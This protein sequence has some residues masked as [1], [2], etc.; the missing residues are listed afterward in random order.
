MTTLAISLNDA[1]VT[2]VTGSRLVY[3]E[4]GFAL[5]GDGDLVTGRRAMAEARRHPRSVV[6]HFWRHLGL[7][8]VQELKFRHL[9]P[10][11]LASRQLEEIWRSER[12]AADGVV[13][14]VPAWM[15]RDSLGVLLGI[16]GELEL[17]VTALVDSAVACSRRAY[18]GRSLLHIDLSLHTATVSRIA[19]EEGA[20][21]DRVELVDAAGL[22]ALRDTWVA[23]IAEAFV[24]QSRFD[25]LHTAESEQLLYDRLEAWLET[26]QRSGEVR[27]QLEFG[28]H[29]HEAALGLLTFTEAVSGIYQ[30][31]AGHVRSLI[32]AAESPALQFTRHTAALPGLVDFL[33]AR[34]GGEPFVLEEAAAARGALARAPAATAGPARLTRRLPWDQSPVEAP[35]A[36]VREAGESPSH[37][38]HGHRA[39]ALDGDGLAIGT[40]L[41][42]ERGITLAADMAG[43]SRRHCVL[44]RD[45]GQCIVEDLSRYG[46][47]LNG[48][49]I[50]RSAVLQA[51]DSL[52]VGTPGQ[53]FRLIRVVESD[54]A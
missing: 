37:L 34:A 20:A 14:A 9:T 11:D 47:W 45:N 8:P 7:E 50:E 36:P 53:E 21:T 33:V 35:A 41:G 15:E 44:R 29:T 40:S 30:S 43:V 24:R 28:G 49:R 46:T 2:A 3:R 26:A 27:M 51:G 6:N 48:S 18:P 52:R 4:P 38:L 5:L 39:W 10:A 25:P 1:A 19:Q 31:L 16:A 12:S 54:D 23:V 13:F 17:P 32:R 22:A 42:G